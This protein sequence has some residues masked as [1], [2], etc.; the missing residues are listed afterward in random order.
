[1]KDTSIATR[2]TV[3]PTVFALQV[4]GIGLFQQPDPRILAK[5]EVHL[6]VAGV[7]GDDLRGAAL[8]QAIGKPA[9]RSADIQTDLSRDGDIPVIEGALQLESAAAD[10]LEI[11][12]E[13]ADRRIPRR[14]AR[15]L[16]RLS[17]RRPEPCPQ[18]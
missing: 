8:E 16:S 15:P 2:S 14:L 3:T 12:A 10:V 11:F 13:Q 4:A 6:T 1:M 7:D 18:E 17:D 9:G 5:L